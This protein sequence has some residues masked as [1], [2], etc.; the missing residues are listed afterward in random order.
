MLLKNISADYI[1]L[2]VLKDKGQGLLCSEWV[3]R[4]N[5]WVIP[6]IQAKNKGNLDQGG[7]M[8]GKSSNQKK[9]K[10]QILD[11]WIKI[12]QP[13]E[14][15]GGVSGARVHSLQTVNLFQ[16]KPLPYTYKVCS[17]EMEDTHD[18]EDVVYIPFSQITA[19]TW[20]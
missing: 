11:K 18:L 19:R 13:R 14:V 16:G 20:P 10:P 9:Q 2:R 5:Q 8:Y 1:A 17:I 7:R 6:V 4:P 3:V 12:T 15:H